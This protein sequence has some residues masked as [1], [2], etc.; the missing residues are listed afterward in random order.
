ML[1]SPRLVA[2]RSVRRSD[3]FF[4][5]LV[6]QRGEAFSLCATLVFV[7]SLVAQTALLNAQAATR[8]THHPRHRSAEP[9]ISG[10]DGAQTGTADFFGNFTAISTPTGALA[11]GRQPN[12]SF[13]LATGTYVISSSGLTY[14]QTDI[15]PHYE[16]LL[17]S[18]A[19]LS[20][21]PDVFAKGCIMQ[22]PAGFGSQPG[23]FV[24]STTTGI[25]VFAGLGLVYP[26][27]TNGVY[28]LSGTTSFTLS[29]FMDSSAGN[30]TAADLNK[31]GN[32]DLVIVDNPIATTAQVTVM[33]GNANGT[34]K[35]GVTYPIAGN[36]S[37]AAVVDDVNG[38]GNPDIVAVSGDQQISVL[39]GNGDGTFQ[40]AK[41]LAAPA[42]PG[43]TSAASTPI[44]NLITADLR[45]S[46]KKDIICSNGLVLLGKGDG[47]F[48]AV[49]APAFPYFQDPINAGGPSLASGDVNND[50]KI[51]LVVNNSSS[52]STWFGKGDGTF[53]QGQS[54][55]TI[56]TDGFISVNDLDGDGNADVFVG[57]GEGEFYGGDEGSPNLAYALMGN[58]NGSFQGAPQISAGEYTGNNLADVTGSGT[59]DLITNTINTPYGFP[60]TAVSTFTV[61]LGTG[62]GSFN[63]VATP[64]TPPAS[65]VLN[66][67][68]ITGAD[69]AIADSFAV[70]D[71]N[72]DGKADL[73]FLDNNLTAG[74][75]IYPTP[76]YFTALSN[77]DGSFGAPTPHALPQ[78]APA[79]DFDISN[80]ASGVQIINLSRGGNAGL[81]VAFDEIEGGT[82]VTNPYNL[83]FAVLAGNGDGT[84]KAPV[85]TSTYSSATASS[86]AF[87]PSL[88]AIADINGDGNADLVVNIPGT[89]VVNFQLQNQFVIFLG[90]GD[91]TFKAAMPIYTTADEYG[92]PVVADLNKDGK[93]DLAFLA[94]DPTGQAQL[95]IALGNG[96]GTF[97]TPTILDLSGGDSIRS[98]S[99]A[100]ADFN[101]DG[102]IDLA[103]FQS[104]DF[105]GIFYGNGD[106]TF[107]SV[108]IGTT[109]AP[110]II[111]KDLLNLELSGP[112]VAASLSGGTMPDILVGNTILLNEYG[113]AVTG[114]AASSTS[115]SASPTSITAGQSVTLTAT[116]TGPSGNTTSPTGTVTFEDGTTTLGTGTLTAG[117]A[118]DATTSLPIGSDSI[119]AVYSGDTNFSGSTSSAVTVTVATAP[120]SSFALTNSGN[121]S[122]TAGATTGNTSTITATPSNGFTG[123]VDLT[124]AVAG[125]TG[126][127]SPVTCGFA[128]DS[129]IL[130]GPAAMTDTLTLATASTTTAGGYTVTVTGVSG[131]ITQTTTVTAT[132]TA[133]P[134]SFGLTNGGAIA[135]NPGAT[136]G[137]TSTITITPSGG[138]TG[139][140]ALT[141]ALTTSPSGASNP[142]TFS[143]GTTSPVSIIGTTAGTG[144]LTVLTTAATSGA[145]VR[146]ILRVNPWYA[147][148]GSALACLLLFGIPARRRR[149]RTLLGMIFLLTFLNSGTVSCGGSG[150]SGG[151]GGGNPGTT[152][153]SYTITVTGTAGSVTKTTVVNLTVN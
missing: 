64:I 36:Y 126:A 153:G 123:A 67:T 29:S 149:L 76:V 134:A 147:A 21:T 84:F 135:V 6:L 65:F 132:V 143:F 49:S 130:T 102:N 93:L 30:L 58:G 62:K 92:T 26:S 72:G 50:G 10:V 44:V 74:N 18:E 41:S 52:I 133:A 127:T 33:L 80:T 89:T 136:S 117:V 2:C 104:S 100:A 51:D 5:P 15:T 118:T 81:I 47:T 87:P 13:G 75:T 115:L 59:L 38:D 108:N 95:V 140:V 90:N 69:K 1:F 11:L 88:V 131:T 70:G 3:S 60:D 78:I 141:A 28:I 32:G 112:A 46:G 16:L 54:Y 40:T 106:G 94:E 86:S 63:P 43:F 96:D 120:V 53:T 20:T 148:G 129:V 124:C 22:P 138:F 137:N 79:A 101:A 151:S 17:H 19:Q 103:L 119:T 48:T 37:V 55:A 144:T 23:V 125:P 113:A 146:P 8:P 68:T 85:I 97:G 116:V 107:T 98:S 139:S 122:I 111:P 109:S 77:G 83:G 145:L 105:S 7:G 39:L 82:G 31:D 110:N 142:P 42:L 35:N 114:P 66:G 57:L 128:S 4:L 45:G 121:L 150:K 34:F 99:L 25:K 73:V 71:I 152:P 24:G 56:P 9:M 91:G 12:C 14:T 61:Q 27:L